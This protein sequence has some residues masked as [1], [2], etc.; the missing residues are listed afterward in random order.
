[1]FSAAVAVG[2][3][4]SSRP[5]L[6]SAVLLV[7]ILQ[8]ALQVGHSRQRMASAAGWSLPGLELRRAVEQHIAAGSIIAAELPAATSLEA[9]GTWR[10]ADGDLLARLCAPHLTTSFPAVPNPLTGRE[11]AAARVYEPLDCE[12]RRLRALDD[13]EAW[14]GENASLYLVARE[15]FPQL[16][17]TWKES[18]RIA[19]TRPFGSTPSDARA[20]PETLS[21]YE[22]VR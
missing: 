2:R 3:I 7:L 11:L 4:R 19:M 16:P 20:L 5:R 12:A 18:G 6:G 8:A 17:G 13:L 10:L 1:V 22:L 21:I 15:R 9:A 14:A